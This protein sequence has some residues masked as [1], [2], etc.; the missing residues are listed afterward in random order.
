MTINLKLMKHQMEKI[1]FNSNKMAN[2]ADVSYSVIHSLLG[3]KS[4]LENV[5]LK[6]YRPFESL[7]TH[8]ELI[9]ASDPYATVGQYEAFWTDMLEE[10]LEA[11]DVKIERSG[12]PTVVPREEGGY[13]Q[14]LPVYAQINWRYRDGRPMLSL[15]IWDQS[16]YNEL[17]NKS[18]RDKKELV[19]IWMKKEVLK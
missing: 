16:L 10:A 14:P 2:Y 17:N 11:S 19:R 4:K 15:R 7:F 5:S 13:Y 9:K 6:V 3:G 1:G 8:T 12:A 18:Q